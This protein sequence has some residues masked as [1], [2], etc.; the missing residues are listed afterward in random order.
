MTGRLQQLLNIYL[1]GGLTEDQRRELAAL[2]ED[3]EAS[4]QLSA[5]LQDQLSK[6][7]FSIDDDLPATEDRIVQRVMKKIKAAAPV[8]RIP[9][10]RWAAAAVLLIGVSTGIYL[11]VMRQRTGVP[12]A[13]L[14]KDIAPGGNKAVLTL[15]DG[16]SVVLDSAA[17]GTIAQQGNTSIKKL[18]GGQIAYD[19]KG[20]AIGEVMMNTM[21]T[22]RGG[23]YQLTLPDGTRVWLNAASSITYPAA[24]PEG[25]RRVAIS[26]EVYFEVAKNKQR[27]FVVDVDGK[28]TVEVLGTGFDINAYADEESVKTT[29]LEGSVKVGSV[30]LRPGEQAQ[31]G[32]QGVSVVHHADLDKVM[33]WKNGLFNFENADLK[34]VMR[35]LARWYDIEVVY[36]KG[37]PN[38]Q[39]EGE[40]N[41]N[42]NLSNLLKVLARAD[43][44]FRI[45]EGRRLVVLP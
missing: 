9:V 30:L 5:L 36:E 40:I 26:G 33:A 20:A 8:R 35:Q 7:E 10:W 3:Q 43:V 38:V 4:E 23:Q 41:R 28:T 44:K 31:A 17:D 24:F 18:A 27:P 15:A 19:L 29:L 12:V 1:S 13:R 42:I 21:R 34:E 11:G 22:P 2:L 37:V 14:E 16:S 6:R 25:N 45:E 32:S 39:F